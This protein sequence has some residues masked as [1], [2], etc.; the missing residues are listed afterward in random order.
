[1]VRLL[2]TMDNENDSPR[3]VNRW[4]R[5]WKIMQNFDV[6][7]T[8]TANR[9]LLFLHSVLSPYARRSLLQCAHFVVRNCMLWF[10]NSPFD[11]TVHL[12]WDNAC[13][14]NAHEPKAAFRRRA[15]WKRIQLRTDYPGERNGKS[16]FSARVSRTK[17]IPLLKF[18]SLFSCLSV[19][20]LCWGHSVLNWWISFGH[21][22]C[23]SGIVWRA[24]SFSSEFR[25]I[26]LWMNIFSRHNGQVSVCCVWVNSAHCLFAGGVWH[27]RQC[28]F[29]DEVTTTRREPNSIRT[30]QKNS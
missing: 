20:R 13:S 17:K 2:L 14:C 18:S 30:E 7:M 6:R 1:M 24:N 22:H 5:P 4:L 16:F 10:G 19:C 9:L 21:R 23:S 26:Q 28:Q 3:A 29:V 12:T 11:A 25:V 27:W 8:V 15:E